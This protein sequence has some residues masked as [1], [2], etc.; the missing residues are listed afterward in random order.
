MLIDTGAS[1]SFLNPD[2]TPTYTATELTE[3]IFINTS[4]H[5]IYH[6]ARFV[7]LRELN[8]RRAYDFLL[9][10]FH[11]YFD[12]IVDLESLLLITRNAALTIHLKDNKTS[13]THLLES[14]SRQIISLPVTVEN[15]TF[16]KDT[17]EIRHG[18]HIS[19][20]LNEAM[21][22]LANVEVTNKN[23]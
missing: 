19:G 15:G 10:Y 6:R 8:E 14:M 16:S 17:L 18:L 12:G 20:G 23:K 21:K 11:P 9:F 3:P 4:T 13:K 5:K 22:G 2:M 1:N 7:T